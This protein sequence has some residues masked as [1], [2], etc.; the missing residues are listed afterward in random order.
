VAALLV[1]PAKPAGALKGIG[2]QLYG[3]MNRDEALSWVI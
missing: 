3:G 2:K 1:L